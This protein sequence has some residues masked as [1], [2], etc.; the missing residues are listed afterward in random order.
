MTTT[1]IAIDPGAGAIKIYHANGR[2]V[3]PAIVATDGAET[4][5]ALA[6]L[7]SG[8]PPLRIITDRGAFLVGPQAHSWG[9]P[10]ENLDPDRL[11]G[12]PELAALVYA[13]MA[14]AEIGSGRFSVIVGLPLE[15]LTGDEAA[16]NAAAVKG[17]LAGRHVWSTESQLHRVHDIM[18]HRV[19]D[20]IIN[21]VKVTSQPVGAL[22]DY[23]L[24]DEGH[25]IPDNKRTAKGE[26][27]II[28]IGMNT[29]ELLAVSNLQIIQRFTA[30]RASGVRRLLELCNPAELYSRGEMD[31][32]LRA[33]SLDTAAALPIW[34]AEVSDTIN[35]RWGDSW[36]RFAAVIVTGGG[37]LLLRDQLIR[38]FAGRAWFPDDPVISTARG[39]YKF[40]RR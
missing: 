40:S 31:A 2:A 24:D 29:I 3:I 1:T 13:A 17:W 37:S 6:G 5:S 23:L 32:Q 35:K 4:V 11:R 33:G 8:A 36:R 18:L 21:S 30:G 26:I 15:L 20:I 39:L 22:M 25:Y 34:A 10:C 14:D 9:R 27:G 38:K 16:A 12:S 28:S 7:D 19:H